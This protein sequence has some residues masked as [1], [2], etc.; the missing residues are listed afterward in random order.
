ML[1]DIP[2]ARRQTIEVSSQSPRFKP[3]LITG[4]G[5]GMGALA[6]SLG[7]L[8]FLTQKR[9]S[10]QR[11]TP[12][13]SESPVAVTSSV[14]TNGT[15]SPLLGH[16][17]YSE[18]PLDQLTP[19]VAD[20]QIKL[21]TAAAQAFKEMEAAAQAA[22]IPLI[23]LSGFRTIADQ[24]ELFFDVKAERSQSPTQ[25]AKVSAP[26]NRS[27]HHT[28]YALDIGDASQ[29][30]THLQI[31]FEQ[32]PTFRW[33]QTNAL[34]YHFEL[35]FPEGNP[36]GVSYEP[37]HWRFVGDTESLETFYDARNFKSSPDPN[38]NP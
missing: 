6:I 36:Q 8:F 13:E 18:A 21:R 1:D 2:E 20:G 11:S 19:I 22:G 16:L 30:E 10:S 29:P 32:T 23:P 3:L 38:Q 7:V 35:S 27:E 25:R 9:P 28:G 14:A 37:W 34:K 17:R 31:R 24:T 26:P 12:L 15:Q 33:L 4:G 5:I